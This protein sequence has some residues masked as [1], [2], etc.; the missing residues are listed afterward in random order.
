MSAKPKVVIFDLYGTLVEIDE[1]R[2]P[3]SRLLKFGVVMGRAIR[4]DDRR[5][6]MTSNLGLSGVADR[7]GIPVNA[8]ELDSLERD[9][10]AELASVRVF[11]DVHATLELLRRE[12]IKTALCSNL[13]AAY[14]VPAKTMLPTFDSYAF[15]FEVGAIKPE[16]AIYEHVLRE[17]G[18]S[19][20]EAVM[21]GDTQK[22]DVEGPAELGIKAFLLK[23]EGEGVSQEPLTDLIEQVL[24]MPEAGH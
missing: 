3:F 16:A 15:S 9:I 6:I 24:A 4:P 17:I 8:D 7:F 23:R 1:P 14:A 21:I 12:G 11:S 20:S 2:S 22:A 5:E 13:A 19:A 10:Y 18:C